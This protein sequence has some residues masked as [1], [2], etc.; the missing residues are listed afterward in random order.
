MA[1]ILIRWLPLVN[2]DCMRNLVVVIVVVVLLIV[3]LVQHT[4]LSKFTSTTFSQY[5]GGDSS[6]RFQ[7]RTKK[8]LV[9]QLHDSSST[10][11]D[12]STGTYKDS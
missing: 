11:D 10:F 3:Q 6:T 7:S 9:T 12:A 5:D 2:I 1:S 8:Q 4:I